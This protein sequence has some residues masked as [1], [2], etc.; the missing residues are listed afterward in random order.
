MDLGKEI[1]TPLPNRMASLDP[2]AVR[3]RGGK[4]RQNLKWRE[5]LENNSL[6]NDFE[7][8]LLSPERV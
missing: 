8:E 5:A 1:N 6:G 7:K 4:G 2:Y 3:I